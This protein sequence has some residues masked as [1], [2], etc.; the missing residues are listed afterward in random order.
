[1]PLLSCI[2]FFMRYLS[3]YVLIYLPTYLPT[4]LSL[5]NIDL[6]E[7]PKQP[8]VATLALVKAARS[9]LSFSW[10]WSRHSVCLP[11]HTGAS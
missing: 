2:L 11:F 4:Y 10:P 5:R 3:I 1:M 8:I 7:A 9:A 6:L